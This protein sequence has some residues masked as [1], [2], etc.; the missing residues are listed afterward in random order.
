MADFQEEARRRLERLG[1]LARPTRADLAE[2][3][4]RVTQTEWR[5]YLEPSLAF[6]ERTIAG[7]DHPAFR[8]L[9]GKLERLEAVPEMLAALG[10]AERMEEPGPPKKADA[11]V[12][13]Q[14][15]YRLQGDPIACLFCLANHFA[16][17]PWGVNDRLKA[18]GVSRCLLAEALRQLGRPGHAAALL[19]EWLGLE[20]AWGQPDRIA[21]RLQERL[22]CLEP[23]EAAAL[24]A[25]MALSLNAVTREGHVVALLE[26]WLGLG[27]AVWQDGDARAR[28][29][30][31]RLRG[32]AA[33]MV[34]VLLDTMA[35]SLRVSGRPAHAVALLESWL[36]L[37]A[38]SWEDADALAARLRERLRGVHG[39][40]ATGLLATLAD[41]L[42][43]VGRTPQSVALLQGWLGLGPA[44]G[45]AA[46]LGQRLRGLSPDRASTLLR[47][48]AR[49][50]GVER[51]GPAALALLEGWLGLNSAAWQDPGA[52]ATRL[53][54]RL[55]ALPPADASA[56]VTTLADVLR[57]ENRPGHAVALV[58]AW[59][60]IGPA[61]WQDAG[62]L[63]RHL[64]ERTQGLGAD[65]AAL[66]LDALADALKTVGRQEHAG[67]LVAFQ[68][69]D[70]RWL[71][72]GH[73]R[74]L[75]PENAVGWLVAWF[76]FFAGQDFDRT[77][78]VCRRIVPF[79]RRSI[80]R[81]SVPPE[82]RRRFIE[83][84]TTLRHAIVWAVNAAVT[85]ENH[86]ALRVSRQVGKKLLCWEESLRREMLC[87]D[88]ELGHRIVLER[89]LFGEPAAAAGEGA[90][91]FTLPPGQ[92]AFPAEYRPP[93]F[94]GPA[95][96]CA[97]LGCF[98]Q[99]TP[100]DASPARP[101]G[102]SRLGPGDL[103]P[104]LHALDAQLREGVTPDRLA[105]NLTRP[106]V[107]LWA[108]FG[109]NGQLSWTAYARDGED[110]RPLAAGIGRLG[111]QTRSL[112][113]WATDWHDF[114]LDLGW[115]WAACLSLP[116]EIQARVSQSLARIG[117]QLKKAGPIPTRVWQEFAL[118]CDDL[119]RLPNLQ[120]RVAPLRKKSDHLLR[121][122]DAEL[123]GRQWALVAALCD[124]RTARQVEECLDR[125]TANFIDGVNFAWDLAALQFFLTPETDL[126]IQA[127]DAL[128]AAPV[129]HLAV[130]GR[131]LFQQVRSVRS[132]TSLLVLDLQRRQEEIDHRRQEAATKRPAAS[133]TWWSRLRARWRAPT[134]AGPRAGMLTASWFKK[135]D[136]VPRAASW[137][138]H[139]DQ[140]RLA[141]GAGLD[142]YS[143]AEEP[144]TT[145]N[146]LG[147]ALPAGGPFRVA[148]LCAHGGP[149]GSASL[150]ADP[151]PDAPEV[152]GHLRETLWKGPPCDLGWIEFLVQ[153]SCTVGRLTQDG[154]RD[155]DGFCIDLALSRARSV[156]AARWPVH[157]RQACAFA[158]LVVRHYLNLRQTEEPTPEACLRARAVNLARRD[159][160]PAAT[161]LNTV[162]AFELYG[163]S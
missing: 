29:L 157:C 149:N 72:A 28:H 23:A 139:H 33:E 120:G 89:Y 104:E 70:F 114:Q 27:A 105:R 156:L 79:L 126:I 112:L 4:G 95:P 54:E 119:E 59:L 41:S 60:G 40:R 142:W 83:K 16:L 125:Q 42:G 118:L 22:R 12:W 39:D 69:E 101:P 159:F 64:R 18:A 34:A 109:L 52:L 84:I 20:A 30:H 90:G 56:L 158:N 136:E 154:L 49:S 123:A 140:K 25:T 117:Q 26:T 46:D 135:D 113:R 45:T 138:L 103:P 31:E 99:R 19:E 93:D 73:P 51:R 47:T 37:G 38:D 98:D 143:L 17:T 44:D 50:L 13:L 127:S 130:E 85:H 152:P 57:W 68:C 71:E 7:V 8:Q 144:A 48:L 75:L 24:L 88:A 86:P 61:A 81:G 116:A 3:L 6:V 91:A 55:D 128:V 146:T 102:P 53:R 35:D 58:E 21:T 141:E 161:G 160:F 107:L 121:D 9:C 78:D 131:P 43:I 97:G 147:R 32:V 106:E 129:A 5:Q 100:P 151:D 133:P 122:Q 124:A 15:A 1:C 96:A 132:A 74:A 153:V 92:L 155:A 87:W 148:T 94:H 145:P 2:F 80:H 65:H 115:A 76:H 11:L 163:L 108:G 162:A 111:D 82:D 63:A 134:A 150:R 36:G 137:Q 77:L 10:V 14:A 67:W 66:L 110:V 62:A